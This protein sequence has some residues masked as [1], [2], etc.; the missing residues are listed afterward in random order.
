MFV[1]EFKSDHVTGGAEAYN[2]K[3]KGSRPM[4]ITWHL[5]RPIHAKF[6]KKTNE[7]VVD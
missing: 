5:D 6:L 7:L 4:T 1:R 3:H 2:V